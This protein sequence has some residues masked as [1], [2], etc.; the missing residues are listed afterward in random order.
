MADQEVGWGGRPV[1]ANW[2]LGVGVMSKKRHCGVM[3]I[4]QRCRE[5]NQKGVTVKDKVIR[6]VSGPVPDGF[7]GQGK[8][9]PCG[10]GVE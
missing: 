7:H 1:T 5:V 2:R 4:K 9:I 3:F 6:P 10:G 8:E